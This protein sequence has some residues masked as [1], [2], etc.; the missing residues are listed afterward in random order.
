MHFEHTTRLHTSKHQLPNNHLLMH[1]QDISHYTS[2]FVS[3]G[4][5]SESRNIQQ[6]A[7]ENIGESHYKLFHN[8]WLIKF[9]FIEFNSLH[10]LMQNNCLVGFKA[11]K[12]QDPLF[13]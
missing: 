13:E 4:V 3:L 6:H 5:T 12:A 2:Q 9:Y 8:T 11:T 10:C 1:D 7:A